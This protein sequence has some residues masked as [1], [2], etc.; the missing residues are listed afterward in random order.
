[1]FKHYLT[2]AFRNLLRNK[3]Q[4]AFSIVGLSVAFFC[5][6]FCAYFIHGYATMDTYYA[7]H[8]RVLALKSKTVENNR[9]E[10]ARLDGVE[11]LKRRFPEVE[12]AFGYS[13]DTNLGYKGMSPDGGFYFQPRLIECDTTLQALYNP[14][15]LAGSWDEAKKTENS[16][17]MCESTA[18]RLFG[19]AEKAIGRQF[20]LLNHKHP[21][22]RQD[23]LPVYTVRAVV[24]DLAYNNTFMAFSHLDAWVL[25]DVEGHSKRQMTED[26]YYQD[27]AY[28]IL[29]REGTDIADFCNRLEGS[30][31]VANRWTITLGDTGEKITQDLPMVAEPTWDIHNFVH[32]AD[33]RTSQIL[34]VLLMVIISVPGLLILLSALSNFFHILLSNIMMRRR[35]YTLR[36]A[37][38]AHTSDLWVM[39]STQVLVTL[40]LVGFCTLL[41]VELC[42]PILSFQSGSYSISIDT[43]EMLVQSFLH[44]AML[45]LVG[46]GVGWLAVAR[47]RKDSL[48]EAMKTS[49]GRRP[50]RHVGRNILLGWQMT[51]GLFF[52]TLLSALMLQIQKNEDMVFPN[53]TAQEKS[54]IVTLPLM[55]MNADKDH[56]KPCDYTEIHTLEAELQSIPSI[57]YFELESSHYYLRGS[58][59][60]GGGS[61]KLVK[62]NGDTLHTHYTTV[63]SGTLQILN[64][65]LKAGRM[66]D[67]PLEV[68]VDENFVSSH[69][70]TVGDKLVIDP[71][72]AGSLCNFWIS[73]H[74]SEM[75]V[76]AQYV[77]IVGVIDNLVEYASSNLS[78]DNKSIDYVYVVLDLR[79]KG[80]WMCRSYPG[81][82]DEMR[83]ELNKLLVKHGKIN[84]GDEISLTS[85]ADGIRMSNQVE[86]AFLTHFWL[87]AG[88]ALIITLLGINSAITMDT[89]ARRKE[90]AIR[91]INGAKSW[92]IAFRFF[93][94]YAILLA[95]SAVIAFSCS[96]ILIDYIGQLGYRETF[97]YGPLFFLGVLLLMALF[98]A[99]TVGY[100]I[101]RIS[102]INP[103][104]IVK[105]E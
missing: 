9:L 85:L 22:F 43:H 75:P 7:N 65:G 18:R 36:R 91:K 103:A 30:G 97:N 92:H 87:F 89:T 20:E 71:T 95:I 47:I 6:G 59:F 58:N 5:F 10:G 90:M 105:S 3:F 74:N 44:I 17:V 29:L 69:H 35:E 57:R 38:G 34:F 86:R 53:L 12:A 4:T 21:C 15:L 1:M 77:T 84:E 79:M 68:L 70:L 60:G 56:T 11:E 8:D 28:N 45:M 64:I 101:W 42:T 99:L 93:R 94:L 33:S 51:I 54:E 14:R 40:L 67:S 96:Y 61:M 82:G 25:N 16:F 48:Q 63:S 100:H 50:G 41:I 78:P 13:T 52:L 72:I 81:K 76:Y 98:V 104:Q 102:H 23:M 26:G 55:Y 19:D 37:H 88:I 83:R 24:E 80:Y 62:E 31:I 27:N 46:L 49:T 39:V 73:N 2:I 66:P 32:T